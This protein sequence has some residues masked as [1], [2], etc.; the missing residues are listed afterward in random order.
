[1]SKCNSAATRLPVGVEGWFCRDGNWAEREGG[2]DT[3]LGTSWLKFSR[4]A[5]SRMLLL[6][7][8]NWLDWPGPKG[9]SEPCCG[10]CNPARRLFSPFFVPWISFLLRV[11]GRWA[12]CVAR[13]RSKFRWWWSGVWRVRA[14]PAKGSFWRGNLATCGDCA[15]DRARQIQA[16]MQCPRG[17]GGGA[18]AL[19]AYLP[20]S[21]V[22]SLQVEH[23]HTSHRYHSS[24]WEDYDTT[25]H[26][27]VDRALVGL[28][29]T[30]ALGKLFRRGQDST[31]FD[32][33]LTLRLTPKMPTADLISVWGQAASGYVSEAPI[34]AHY[35]LQTE[36][37]GTSIQKSLL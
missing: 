33:F 2:S 16:Q 21:I 37:P 3:R 19:T 11:P 18:L 24:R 36:P 28:V 12:V 30:N 20:P 25:G 14:V 17:G 34:S 31:V 27:T 1:V 26:L 29:A 6:M 4:R 32:T 23:L 7:T 15:A 13:A 22:A 8:L 35:L 10:A 5:C 9:N